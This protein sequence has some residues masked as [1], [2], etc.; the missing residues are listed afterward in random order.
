QGYKARLS[1][2]WTALKQKSDQKN[3]E[4]FDASLVRAKNDGAI[5]ADYFILRSYINLLLSQRFNMNRSTQ[6]ADIARE[7]NELDEAGVIDGVRATL[8]DK[9]EGI[10]KSLDGQVGMCDVHSDK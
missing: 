10:L 1:T 4:D 2:I 6:L 3:L 9:G 8:Q 5:P 7:Y